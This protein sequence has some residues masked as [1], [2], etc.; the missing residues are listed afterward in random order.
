V[1]QMLP[2]FRKVEGKNGPIYHL[3]KG[4]RI[5]QTGPNTFLLFTHIDNHR[6]N[7][8]FHKI[9]AAF[10]AAVDIIEKN[11]DFAIANTTF[12]CASSYL[13]SQ[14]TFMQVAKEWFTAKESNWEFGTW[15]KYKGII[16]NHLEEA[17]FAHFAVG[18]VEACHLYSFLVKKNANPSGCSPS[19][20]ECIHSIIHGIFT[21]SILSGLLN[22]NV[23]PA[24][25]LLK[26]ILPPRRKRRLNPPHPFNAEELEVFLESIQRT[27][28]PRE[29]MLIEMMGRTG[30]RLGEALAVKLENLNIEKREYFVREQFNL[31]DFKAPKNNIERIVELP[32]QLLER[33]VPYVKQIKSSRAQAGMSSIAGLLFPSDKG[34]PIRDQAIQK[35]VK[36]ACNKSE[37]PVRTPHDLRHTFA[38]LS[39]AGGIDPKKVK[40]LLGHQSIM[41]TVEIYEAFLNKTQPAAW[42]NVFS[43]RRSG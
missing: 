4:V 39:I 28:N 19:T 42:A 20:I 1:Q 16:A 13:F 34:T 43:T 8:T 30:L 29:A 38:T 18:D 35:L 17:P 41:T 32:P 11:T 33:L 14:S 6:E 25:G 21:H 31:G 24:E 37:L 23:N 10:W 22:T 9:D 15:L 26:H 12:S 7:T 5:Q 2:D 27:A 36:K 40:E 3:C